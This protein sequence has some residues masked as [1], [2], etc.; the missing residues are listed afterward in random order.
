MAT[1]QTLVRY[2]LKPAV[3]V[4]CLLPL[5]QQGWLA[6][7]GNLGANPIGELTNETGVW[8][9]RLLLVTLAIT[10]LRRLTGWGWL[11]SVR[12]MLGLYAFAYG[13]LHLAVY[14]G[15]NQY[16]D[17]SLIAGDLKRPYIVA[18]YLALLFMVPL[19][20]T[21]T[22]A[23]VRRLGRRWQKLHRLVYAVAILGVVHYLLLVKIDFLPPVAYAAVLAVLLAWRLWAWQIA[24]RL[25]SLLRRGE[26]VTPPR[27]VSHR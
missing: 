26:P 7:T 23:M 13:M 1:R 24:P 27:L 5:L 10:P 15:L 25:G 11:I 20:A 12:R 3:F 16:F 9:L 2:G 21:S 14:W 17:L 19:A 6:Y 4:L 18:G 22:D 8:S